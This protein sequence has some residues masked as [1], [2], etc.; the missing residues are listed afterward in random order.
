MIG[1]I[2]PIIRKKTGWSLLLIFLGWFY[3]IVYILMGTVMFI[4]GK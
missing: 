2:L 1:D 3:M 4:S